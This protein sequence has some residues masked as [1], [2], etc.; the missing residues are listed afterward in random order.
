M[1]GAELSPLLP[2][3]RPAIEVRAQGLQAFVRSDKEDRD[4]EAHQGA[5][6]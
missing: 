2:A 6:H 5:L 4:T 3:L 1:S